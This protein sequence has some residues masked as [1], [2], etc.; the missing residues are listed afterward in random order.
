MKGTIIVIEISI[1]TPKR[2][3][4]V[5]HLIDLNRDFLTDTNDNLP[6]F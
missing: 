1:I 5:I 6:G 3:K 2:A 4:S